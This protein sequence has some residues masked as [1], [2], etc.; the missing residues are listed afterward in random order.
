MFRFVIANTFD[1]CVQGTNYEALAKE[2]AICEE[3]FVVDT[4]TG[5]WMVQDT[6][7]PIEEFPPILPN[8]ND[9]T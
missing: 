5:L 3:Y 7:A 6:T 1:G 8:P 9:P 4:Q 2:L